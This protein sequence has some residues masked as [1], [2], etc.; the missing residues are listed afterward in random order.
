MKY[1][2]YDGFGIAVSRDASPTEGGSVSIVF[3]E[4]VAGR[5]AVGDH[6]IAVS[7][8]R[9]RVPVEYLRQ[10]GGEIR[11]ILPV[12]IV[13]LERLEETEDGRWKPAG[14]DAA[15]LF[16]R[17][18]AQYRALQSTVT[19]LRKEVEALHTEYYGEESPLF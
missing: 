13:Y 4:P 2:L 10:S 6:S 1:L 14:I 5:L 19:A 15:E 17:L 11:L 7:S 12:G 9:V 8:G 16:V 18:I 3:E